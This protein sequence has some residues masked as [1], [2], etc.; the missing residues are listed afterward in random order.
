M[1]QHWLLEVGV[2]L[3][4][5][6]RM[7]DDTMGTSEKIKRWE[8][9]KSRWLGVRFVEVPSKLHSF[10]CLLCLGFR[11][12]SVALQSQMPYQALGGEGQDLGILA[13]LEA[14]LRGISCTKGQISGVLALVNPAHLR[15]LLQP[16]RKYRKVC[17][18]MNANLR[19]LWYRNTAS[20][21]GWQ[22][23][24][25]F[26]EHIHNLLKIRVFPSAGL[27]GS[28]TASHTINANVANVHS[29][30]HDSGDDGGTPCG[31]QHSPPP[32]CMRT[33]DVTDFGR[34]TREEGSRARGGEP[35]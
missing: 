11:V 26:P 2:E 32:K 10:W 3:G 1:I 27:D 14:W 7:Q 31:S 12:I 24:T 19:Y 4:V 17:C 28:R 22:E 13:V 9:N 29:R 34:D 33:R 30:K 8:R 25:K 16:K 18:D 6:S 5:G 15:A 20:I 23:Q 21:L 35:H